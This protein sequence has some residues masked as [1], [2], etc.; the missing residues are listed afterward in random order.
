MSFTLNTR[1]FSAG[2]SRSIVCFAFITWAL[3]WNA[4]A[5]AQGSTQVLAQTGQ[6]PPEAN[7]VLNGFTGV[8]LNNSGSVAFVGQLAGT[9]NPGVDDLGLYRAASGTLFKVARNGETAPAGGV[10]GLTLGVRPK[11]NSLGHLV[12]EDPQSA[13]YQAT[14]NQATPLAATGALIPTPPGTF[15]D[16]STPFLNQA[17]QFGFFSDV[18]NGGQDGIF[19]HD[20]TLGLQTVAQRG[21][22][23]AG[24]PG[25]FFCFGNIIDI[26]PTNLCGDRV[27]GITADGRLTFRAKLTVASTFDSGI[28]LGSPTGIGQIMREGQASPD[29]NGLFAEM[30]TATLLGTRNPTATSAAGD[31]AWLGGLTGTIDGSNRGIFRGNGTSVTRIARRLQVSPDGNGTLDDFNVGAGP[32]FTDEFLAIGAGGRVV[33]SA[34]FSGSSGGAFDDEA[35]MAG[36]GGPLSLLIRESQTVPGG[37]G[38][39]GHFDQHQ[40]PTGAA[41]VAV[42]SVLT[43]TSA[44]ALDDVGI[45]VTDGIAPVTVVREPDIAGSNGSNSS[46]ILHATNDLGQVV[47]E[48]QLS[49]VESTLHRWTPDL[50]WRTVGGGS[51][52]TNTN[53]T[54]SLSPATVHDVYIDPAV[55]IQVTGMPTTTVRSLQIG[56]GTGRAEVVMGSSVQLTATHGIKIA[57]NGVLESAGTIF[58]DIEVAPS[59]AIVV[60]R[61][62]HIRDNLV[63]DGALQILNDGTGGVVTVDGDFSGDGGFEGGGVLALQGRL[64]PGHRAAQIQGEGDLFLEGSS[65]FEV[66]LGGT[67]LGQFDQ[68]ALEGNLDLRGR[69]DLVA[70]GGYAPRPGD[71]YLIVDLRGT[72]TGEFQGLAEGAVVEQMGLRRLTISY[73]A[74]DGD[75]IGLSTTSVADFDHDD[76]LG[77]RDVDAL[78]AEIAGGGNDLQFDLD[79]DGEVS[80]GDLIRWLEEAGNVNLPSGNSYLLGDANLDGVVDGSD[81][82]IWNSNKF[83]STPAWCKGDFNADGAVDG[84]D[85]GIWNAQKF[86]S[87]DHANRVVPEPGSITALLIGFAVSRRAV[88]RGMRGRRFTSESTMN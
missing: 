84:S 60:Q 53:W 12:F 33:F 61:S 54:L 68:L 16:F 4:L 74:G 49:G 76:A 1:L 20:G 58:G 57:E 14:G 40:T 35:V 45:F 7:G 80:R 11:L 36:N 62:L 42:R 67:D 72:R 85:F 22:L 18:T 88:L 29:G 6:S 32:G 15:Q 83:T 64:R 63:Q 56:G 47:Y 10:F 26:G 23:A 73:R 82:G 34:E 17:G 44:G 25:S 55:D 79:G 3:T 19:R 48:T 43:N 37:D 21:Q 66:E 59:G 30:S 31:V 8:A 78:V 9:S 52:Q 28:F 70:L 75:D 86:T 65:T 24:G 38:R 71:E 2:V 46:V 50:H 69:L 41:H 51:W 81:F 87:A 77:C 13:M 39:F 27:E 5:F